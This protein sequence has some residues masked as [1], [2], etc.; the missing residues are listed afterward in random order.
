LDS[1]PT[2]TESNGKP[3]S[4]EYTIWYVVPCVKPSVVRY[5]IFLQPDKTIKGIINNNEKFKTDNGLLF[6]SNSV[7]YKKV[8]T[9]WQSNALPIGFGTNLE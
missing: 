1:I 2:T 8:L 4:S 6:I 3:T 7:R 5:S 9:F